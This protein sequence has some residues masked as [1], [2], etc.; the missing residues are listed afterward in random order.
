MRKL[1]FFAHKNVKNVEFCPNE[2]YI[3]S[4]NGTFIENDDTDNYII[5]SLKELNIIRTFKADQGDSWGGMKWNH[6]GKFIARVDS[7]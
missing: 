1:N 5:W 3:L 7:H 4:Y 2:E 6:D